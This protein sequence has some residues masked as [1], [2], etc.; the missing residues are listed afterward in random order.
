[1]NGWLAAIMSGGVLALLLTAI[2]LGG[3]SSL[4]TYRLE[5]AQQQNAE[6]QQ[7]LFQQ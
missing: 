3:Y 5:L 1:M 6:Q 4:L 2:C 7:M